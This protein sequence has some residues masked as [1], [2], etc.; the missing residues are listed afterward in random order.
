MNLNKN[1]SLNIMGISA[2]DIRMIELIAQGLTYNEIS[3]ELNVIPSKAEGIRKKLIAKTHTK[4]AASL[5]SFAYR[6]GLLKT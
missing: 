2:L 1:V 3:A 5:I 4:N 6:F